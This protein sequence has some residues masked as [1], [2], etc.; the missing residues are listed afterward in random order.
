MKADSPLQRGKACLCCRKRKMKC[1]GIRP[2]CSQCV[3]ANRGQECKY[4]DKKQISR[5]Q[6][7]QA[8]LAKLEARLRE[9]E[10]EEY[11]DGSP[12]PSLQDSYGSSSSSSSSSSLSPQLTL[13]IPESVQSTSESS[14]WSS[15]L[16]D[17]TVFPEMAVSFAPYYSSQSPSATTTSTPLD[18]SLYLHNGYPQSV[19]AYAPSISSSS[20]SKWWEDPNTFCQQ[21]QMLLDLFL[22]HRHQFA[23]DVHIERFQASL[24]YPSA[25]KPHPALMDAIY[26]TACHL[27]QSP[28][29]TELEPHFLKRALSGISDALQ[30]ND[31]VINVLQASCLLALYFFGR[32]R[33]LEGY[34][35]SSIAARLA[36]SL[37]LHQIR[38]DSWFQ[39]QFHISGFQH[40]PLPTV[41]P[42]SVLLTPPKDA[43]ESEERVA[44]FWQVFI[45]DRAW[46]VATGL[47]SALPDDDHPQAQIETV[48]PTPLTHYPNVL[49]ENGVQRYDP[50]TSYPTLRAKAVALYEKTY[51]LSS[52]SSTKTDS[53]WVEHR[54]LEMSLSQFAS[55][56]PCIGLAAGQAPVTVA[57]IELFVIHTLIYA[58]TLNLHRTLA[59]TS[60]VSYEKCWH[61]AN[62]ITTLVRELS[63]G[64]Y[65]FV[66]AIVSSAWH[67]AADVFIKTL[68][69]P[70]CTTNQNANEIAEQQTDVL[71]TA[72]N[73]LARIFPIAGIHASKTEH[74][75]ATT[76]SSLGLS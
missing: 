54:A 63:E 7:L 2:V 67:C 19:P 30:H 20:S 29:L 55:N 17:E 73:R 69:P 58:S 8:K 21:K 31:R 26:L 12:V 37:G 76:M 74:H 56:L 15:Q 9:L 70:T 45:I 1:D 46:S 16:F 24:A 51:R 44:A 62:N 42:S 10:S 18:S 60:P 49:N 47:P 48:W 5:T 32:G 6:L 35:H 4:H 66:D 57:E 14:D 11:S 59:Q 65:V 50:V 13:T 25:S 61:A 53:Y 34:Y 22:A 39:L 28:S 38:S 72:M 27:S 36:V 75:R 40:Q 43:I 64:D 52:S 23:F 33:I 71:L 3:K 68:V 41:P